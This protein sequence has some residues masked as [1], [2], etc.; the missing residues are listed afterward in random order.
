MHRSCAKMDAG[1]S[2]TRRRINS[3][4]SWLTDW[5]SEWEETELKDGAVIKAQSRNFSLEKP[6]MK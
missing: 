2:G 3:G 6:C 1:P 5:Q 4:M